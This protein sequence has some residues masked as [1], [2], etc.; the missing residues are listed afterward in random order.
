MEFIGTSQVAC[1]VRELATRAARVQSTVLISGESGTGKEL[2]ASMIHS[3]SQ[4]SNKAF[5]AVNCGGM[6]DTLIESELFGY[7]KGAF[8]GAYRVHQGAF[9]RADRGTIFLDE[10]GDMP[11]TAQIKILRALESRKILRLGGTSCI[12][13]N[14]HVIAATNKILIEEIRKEKFREDLYF[15]LAVLTIHLP[16]L[17]EHRED[18]PLLIAHLL[19]ILQRELEIKCL[20]AI[21]QK[22]MDQLIAC[23]WPG[24]VRELRNILERALALYHEKDILEEN[25]FFFP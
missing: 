11:L 24:N 20:P 7:N 2:I 25:D 10:I 18:I 5:E 12:P 19:P 8:T 9:E 4:R 16:P 1:A 21:S 17:R 3:E 22:A 15:R 14:V 13:V 6:P 23:Q